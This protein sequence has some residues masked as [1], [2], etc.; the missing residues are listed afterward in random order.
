VDPPDPDTER[1]GLLARIAELTRALA[2]CQRASQRAAAEFIVEREHLETHRQ[3]LEHNLDWYADLFDHAPIA[4]LTLDS[5]GLIQDINAAAV[6]LLGN[7]RQRLIG[8]P[9]RLYIAP[10]GRRRFLDHMY[11]SRKDTGQIRSELP[12]MRPRGEEIP[13]ELISRRSA[14]AHEAG[15]SFRAAIFDLRERKRVEQELARAAQLE[16]LRIVEAEQRTAQLQRLSAALFSVE[17]NERREL[18]ALLHD[19]LGQRLVAVRLQ[20]AAA[21]RTAPPLALAPVLA[22][23]DDAHAELRSLSFQLSPPILHELGLTAALRWLAGEMRARYGLAVEFVADDEAPGLSSETRYLLFRSARELLLNV[24]KHADTSRAWLATRNREAGLELAVHDDGRGFAP[25][26][27][28]P[29]SRSFGLLSLSERVHARGGRL[30][31]ASRPQEGTQV[32]LLLP[33]ES[34]SRPGQ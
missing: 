34:T 16:R 1:Q 18:A 26:L 8:W 21:A 27:A 30:T 13:I 6:S 32:L 10:D 20:L 9:F 4:Y 28:S 29:H 2:D 17:A 7:D 14:V 19:D 5:A 3:A 23:L 24:V 11:H 33:W 22:I 15:I 31:I 25:E 12:L